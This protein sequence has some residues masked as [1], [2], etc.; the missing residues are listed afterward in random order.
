MATIAAQAVP[1]AGLAPTLYAASGGGDSIEVGECCW[2]MVVNGTT[3]TVATIVTPGTNAYSDA[4][5]DYVSATIP[6]NSG[7]YSAT[8]PFF[9]KLPGGRFDGGTGYAAITWSA[10][11]NVKFAVIK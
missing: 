11:T 2:L 9:V 8:A 7:T 5:A 3:T 4:V 10:T 6:A 1:A